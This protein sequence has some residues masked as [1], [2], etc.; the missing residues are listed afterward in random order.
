MTHYTEWSHEEIRNSKN[1]RRYGDHYTKPKKHRYERR[2]VR[3]LIRLV[4]WGEDEAF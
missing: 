1:L 4:E 2:K 3:T